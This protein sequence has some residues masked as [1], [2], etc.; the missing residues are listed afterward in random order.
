MFV[1]ICLLLPGSAKILAGFNGRCYFF[2][3]IPLLY[4]CCAGNSIVLACQSIT[5]VVVIACCYLFLFHSIT[6]SFVR[7]SWRLTAGTAGTK[8][9]N[10]FQLLIVANDFSFETSSLLIADFV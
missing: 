2:Q 6:V 3:L 7:T 8:R 4:N 10:V 1:C 5:N 9:L